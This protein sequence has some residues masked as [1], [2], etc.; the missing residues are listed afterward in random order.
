MSLEIRKGDKVQVIK[1]KDKGK[2]GKVL[3][4][5]PESGRV[6]IEGINLAKKHMR[7]RSE[8]EQGG[9]KEIPSPIRKEN[10]ALFCSS[11]NKGVRF[12]VKVMED[13]SKVRICRK[14]QQTI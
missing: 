6:I 5:F 4:G 9:I 1:G 11:C 8:T 10:V 3:Q 14:C 13:K 12:S 7:R 2:S